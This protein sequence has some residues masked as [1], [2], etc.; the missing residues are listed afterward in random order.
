MNFRG[1]GHS[2]TFKGRLNAFEVSRNGGYRPASPAE[3][4]AILPYCF[5]LILT[6]IA[7][8]VF[9]G[10]PITFDKR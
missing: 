3:S 8:N 10:Q 2:L 7:L 9:N 5:S 6:C 1:R 4:E